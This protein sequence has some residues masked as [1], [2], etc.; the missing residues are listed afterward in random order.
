MTP[1]RLR[2]LALGCALAITWSAGGPATAQRPRPVRIGAL[3][4]SWGPTTLIVGLRDGLQDLGYREEQDFTIGVR[5]TQGD[6]AEL[7][8]AARDLVRLGVDLIV[9]GETNNAVRAAQLATD[10]I[11][12]VF[13]GGSDPVGS[14]LVRSFARPG[15]NVTGIADI[16][17]ELAPK[18]LEIF[19]DIVPGLKRVLFVYDATNALAPSLLRAHRDAAG[20][21]GLVLVERPVRTQDEAQ[22]AVAGARRG[23][24]D[25]IVSPRLHSLNIPGFI[26][27]GAAAVVPTMFHSAFFVERGGLASY[28]ADRH[29]MGRQ[30]ARLVDRILKGARPA[31][32]P[33]EQANKFE[34]VLNVKTARALGLAIPRLVLLRADRVIDDGTR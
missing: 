16:D 28:A 22:A 3:T 14:G 32:L 30:A 5:F 15:G 2:L 20:R 26:L 31:D 13:V 4:E 27:D 8:T 29:E 24:V 34:L 25:G 1:R 19:R 6:P 12:I 11:P 17:A 18:R 33:V 10:R 9:A 23:V 21:M 7:P